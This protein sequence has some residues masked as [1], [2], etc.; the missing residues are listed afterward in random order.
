VEE[1]D[2]TLIERVFDCKT[3]V[4]RRLLERALHAADTND[5]DS[6]R[7]SIRST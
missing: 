3:Q 2:L 4:R 5:V 7:T 1:G 6:T